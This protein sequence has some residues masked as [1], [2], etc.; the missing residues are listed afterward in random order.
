[1]EPAI[2]LKAKLDRG[3]PVLGLMITYHLWLEAIEIAVRAGVDYLIV[4]TE[5]LDHGGAAVA[6]ACLAGRLAGMPM[7]VRPQST[8]TDD[9]MR[10]A[11]LGPCGVLLPMV[12]SAAQL[13]DAQKGIYMPPRGLRRPGG[14]GNRWVTQFNYESFRTTVEDHFIVI[15]QVESP[16]GIANADAIAGH[17]IVTALGIGPFDLSAHLGVCFEPDHPRQQ[18]AWTDLRAAAARAGK[19]MWAIGDGQQLLAAGH[20]FV[21]FGEMSHLLE[22]ALDEKMKALR[23]G[24][25]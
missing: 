3:E 6:D 14:P 18:Q 7:F 20:H 13:D 25:T 23:S 5:H 22:A 11:D 1:M 2:Q 17:E 9:V 24:G 12:N 21:C 19:P 16:E 15:A 8:D 10:A 4:D